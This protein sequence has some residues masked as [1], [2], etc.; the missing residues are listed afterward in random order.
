MLRGLAKKVSRVWK[1]D[2]DKGKVDQ[3]MPFERTPF[4][5]DISRS[6][7]FGDSAG[8]EKRRQPQQRA[9]WASSSP[10][11][12]EAPRNHAIRRTNSTD[13]QPLVPLREFFHGEEFYN[14]EF[15][16]QPCAPPRRLV[17]IRK[18]VPAPSLAALYSHDEIQIANDEQM[19]VS[20]SFLELLHRE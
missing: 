4:N 9:T 3:S 17:R 5:D 18:P 20:L 16:P 11:G 6:F 12:L 8:N 7:L 19:W 2:E 13:Q 10:H 1:K 14:E 15:Q